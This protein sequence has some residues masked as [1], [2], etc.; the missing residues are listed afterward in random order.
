[1]VVVE[2]K[3]STIV[4]VVDSEAADAEIVA[5]CVAVAEA[6]LVCVDS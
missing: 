1:M 5:I 6:E 4:N 3:L 2:G